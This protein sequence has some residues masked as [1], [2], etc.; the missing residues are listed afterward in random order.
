MNMTQH[1]NA[2]IFFMAFPDPSLISGN[3]RPPVGTCQLLALPPLLQLPVAIQHHI[4][5]LCRGSTPRAR[6]LALPPATQPAG[7]QSQEKPA[8]TGFFFM[9]YSNELQA[10]PPAGN[11]S[12]CRDINL[13]WRL[14]VCQ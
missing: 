8:E 12:D 14:L 1:A 2:K 13:N 3:A 5:R 4:E 10:E 6:S 7:Q 11:C 9:A